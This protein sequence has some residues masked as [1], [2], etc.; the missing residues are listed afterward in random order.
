MTSAGMCV[1]LNRAISSVQHT[2]CGNLSPARPVFGYKSRLRLAEISK[3]M[4]RH[5]H[6]QPGDLT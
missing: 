4:N 6:F 5:V 1:V 3:I 2:A